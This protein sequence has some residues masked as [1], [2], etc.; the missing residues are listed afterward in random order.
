MKALLIGAALLALSV[1]PSFAAVTCWYDEDG[2]YSGADDVQPGFPAGKAT[3]GTQGVYTWGY[4]VKGGP[5]TCP[6]MVPKH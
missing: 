1:A 6:K 5:Q 2:V 4:T 3:K